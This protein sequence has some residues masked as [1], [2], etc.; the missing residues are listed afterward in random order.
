MHAKATPLSEILQGE[1][2]EPVLLHCD[3]VFGDFEPGWD[4]QDI[5]ELTCVCSTC[6]RVIN[7][8][9][10]CT[11]EQLREVQQQ[12][13]DADEIVCPLCAVTNE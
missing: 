4:E 3:E 8:R 2:P 5:Y 6:D 9:L 13:L 7:L 12:L 11:R 10:Q 1:V